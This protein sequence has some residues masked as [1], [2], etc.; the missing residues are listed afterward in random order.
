MNKSEYHAL[1]D[2]FYGDDF[3]GFSR[4]IPVT[5]FGHGFDIGNG[6]DDI[7]ALKHFAEH[8]IAKSLICRVAVVQPRVV[9]MVDEKLSSG[10]V[11]IRH[12]GHG[13][14]SSS[15]TQTV[16]GLVLDGVFGRSTSEFGRHPSTLYHESFDHS[17]EDKAVV[18]FVVHVGKKV[19]YCDWGLVFEELDNNIAFGRFDGD[20]RIGLGRDIIGKKGEDKSKRYQTY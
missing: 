20:F 15:V 4:D 13:N 9:G 19:L 16:C 7:H 12:T 17:V 18:E 11:G 14:G 5:A 6:I 8:T 10:T 1:F 3:D 2:F